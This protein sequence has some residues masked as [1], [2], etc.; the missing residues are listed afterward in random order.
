[1]RVL[2][3][4]PLPEPVTGHS[5]A[6]QVFLDG[7]VRT[8]EADVVDLN[9]ADFR[10][11]VSSLGR[12][13]EVLGMAWRA[14]RRH[15]AADVIYFTISESLAGNLK[16]ILIYM[17]CFGRL[18][19]MVIH[20]HGGAGMRAI[21]GGRY[22]LLALLNGF[23]L[24]RM[25]AVVVLG[26]RHEDMYRSSVAPDRLR[27]VANFAADELFVA[28]ASVERKFVAP[29]PLRLLFLSNLLPGKGHR[30]LLDAVASL[31]AELA[32]RLQVDFAGGFET[33]AQETEFLERLSGVVR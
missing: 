27:S 22:P 9:K 2:F 19:R 7:L 11:G 17:A 26:G 25:G 6:C 31:P 13:F 20:L 12:V 28:D 18:R 16:D 24:R 8:H 5:L 29:G 4:A 21:M 3:L 33:P 30:E 32:G 10:P 1:M 23:F 15:R 14:F